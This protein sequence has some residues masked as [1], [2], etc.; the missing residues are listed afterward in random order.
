MTA[1][2]EDILTSQTLIKEG[3]AVDRMLQ[4]LVIDKNIDINSLLLGD[5]NALIVASRI[6]GYGP[7][8]TTS[9][10]CP[11]CGSTSEHTFD[12]EIQEVNDFEAALETHGAEYNEEGNLVVTLPFSQ[13]TVECRLLTGY[14]EVKSFQKNKKRGKKRTDGSNLTDMFL[15]MMVSVNGDTDYLNRKTFIMNM[16]ARDS[17]FLR[18][19]YAEATP[20]V[21][22]SQNFECS[23]CGFEADVEVPLTVD[24]LWPK[25]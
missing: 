4:S 3:V 7:E 21:D 18:T 10:N 15:N 22:L 20:N 17:R 11:G 14:D 23:E 19:V 24:F 6:T 12:L 1:K 2:E 8:Y 13:A 9:I 25:R 16:P 5:K